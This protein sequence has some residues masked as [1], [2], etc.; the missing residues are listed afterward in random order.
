MWHC[1][2]WRG[3]SQCT[4]P[5]TMPTTTSLPAHDIFDRRRRRLRRERLSKRPG[6]FDQVMADMLIERIEDVR[7]NFSKILLIGAR[8]SHL[9]ATLRQHANSLTIVDTSDALARRVDGICCDEDALS[10]EPFAYDLIVWPGGMEGVN[11]VPGALLRC[12]Y[13]LK[14]D[15]LLLG[16]FIGDGSF[17]AL[18]RAMM[19]ADAPAIIGRMHPQLSHQAIADLL[20][21]IGMTLIVTDVE[22]L[23][24]SYPSLGSLAHDMR[25]AALTNVLCGP[26]RPINR[27]GYARAQAAFY[28]IENAERMTEMVRIIHFSGWAR[29]DIRPQAAKYGTPPSGT[30]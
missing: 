19:A 1:A 12:R 6:Y 23:Q 2:L 4:S 8:N 9:V 18:R 10:V 24:L 7:R 14:P 20:Q 29:D 21:K 5:S 28:A 15:G 30:D 16:C 22:S 17:P 13:A 11:D 3:T 27:A 25:E 26:I